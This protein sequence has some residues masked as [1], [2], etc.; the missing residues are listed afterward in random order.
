M[1]GG[2]A[3][4]ARVEHAM[5]PGVGSE[6]FLFGGQASAVNAW[7]LELP[8]SFYGDTWIFSV[9][10]QIWQRVECATGPGPRTGHSANTFGESVY[11]YGGSRDEQPAHDLWRFDLQHRTWQAI[12]GSPEP[13]SRTLHAAAA[14]DNVLLVHGGTTDPVS[15]HYPDPRCFDVWQFD[16]TQQQWSAARASLVN[17][18]A[19]AFK[20]RFMHSLTGLGGV[21]YMFGG[22]ALSRPE[23]DSVIHFEA[24]VLDDLW[25][26]NIEAQTWTPVLDTGVRPGA[27]F[28]HAAV[29]I[30]QTLW[31]LFGRLAYGQYAPDP[32]WQ[33][34]PATQAWTHIKLPASA[35]T[36][37]AR[38]GLA[39]ATSDDSNIVLFGGESRL[40]INVGLSFR[41]TWLFRPSAAQPW[42]TANNSLFPPIRFSQSAVTLGP[43]DETMVVIF[44]GINVDSGFL[45]DIWSLSLT[46]VNGSALTWRQ[47][48]S[49]VRKN[50]RK[51][52]GR[53]EEKEKGRGK[54]RR[55]KRKKE[56]RKKER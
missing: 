42:E 3:P 44:G 7:D 2:G 9:E 26:Y 48:V 24:E 51:R 15:L 53:R 6:V 27:R 34:D 36:P 31:V 35:E 18:T 33:F 32:A 43:P 19:A 16:L 49:R 46:T 10:L 25:A 47:H 17:A 45:N 20:C 8:S 29:M 23:P 5:A 1:T 50:K 54:K 11:M 21:A 28:D 30:G 37:L 39:I 55:K 4:T 40:S 41:D 13:P 38:G 22:L 14:S 52:E 56:I 12:A